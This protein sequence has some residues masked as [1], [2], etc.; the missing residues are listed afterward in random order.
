MPA[1]HPRPIAFAAGLRE[2]RN[3][4][5]TERQRKLFLLNLV[6]FYANVVCFFLPARKQPRAG[7][8]N[9]GTL[10]RRHTRFVCPRERPD[11]EGGVS[12]C[13]RR[14]T[15][16]GIS[17]SAYP[18]LTRS[19]L[20]SLAREPQI[21]IAKT[22]RVARSP[23]HPEPATSA[24]LIANLLSSGVLASNLKSLPETAGRVEAH[25]NHRKQSVAYM[26][27][28]HS[29]RHASGCASNL[30]RAEGRGSTFDSPVIGRTHRHPRSE[31]GRGAPA[32]EK[33]DPSAPL[34]PRF[35]SRSK[36]SAGR[37]RVPFGGFRASGTTAYL[38]PGA[39]RRT[40]RQ[41][42]DWRSQGGAT[43]ARA[44]KQRRDYLEPTGKKK[45][46]PRKIEDGAPARPKA[47][48]AGIRST[49]AAR[50]KLRRRLAAF[51]S[52]RDWLHD[53]RTRL[54]AVELSGFG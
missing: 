23:S 50:G 45:P 1:H 11:R 28:R 34:A 32:E 30:R 36:G 43:S 21:L 46:H 44:H 13:R 24:F 26:S 40:R 20:S 41:S 29:S 53:A 22:C 27:T 54:V 10:H 48:N 6:Y 51:A 4:G 3:P 38:R 52:G 31:G 5:W 7:K 17:P 39:I 42:G 49:R 25:V 2:Y 33:A 47:P 18:S 14:T 15:W 9:L 8:T 19:S 35:R 37:E 12:R 16:H